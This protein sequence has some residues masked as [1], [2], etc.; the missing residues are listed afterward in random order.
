[1]V[2][3]VCEI[4]NI[5]RHDDDA[6]REVCPMWMEHPSGFTVEDT[7]IIGVRYMERIDD[8]GLMCILH[9]MSNHKVSIYRPN[10]V[11]YDV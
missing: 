9:I 3:K 2:V 11:T 6:D 7:K 10:V 4:A 5:W 8:V 1:M